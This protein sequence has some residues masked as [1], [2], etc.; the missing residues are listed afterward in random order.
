MAAIRPKLKEKCHHRR[1]KRISQPV[2]DGSLLPDQRLIRQSLHRPDDGKLYHAREL[3]RSGGLMNI[4]PDATKWVELAEAW[5]KKRFALDLP[6]KPAW[7]E[8]FS[9]GQYL[10][11]IEAK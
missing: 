11:G 10:V 1:R 8:H 5:L 6:A 4:E 3:Y 7:L 2:G 9:D